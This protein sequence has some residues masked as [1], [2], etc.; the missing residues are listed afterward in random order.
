[1]VSKSELF[2]EEMNS[3]LCRGKNGDINGHIKTVV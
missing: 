2:G 3:F 1:M